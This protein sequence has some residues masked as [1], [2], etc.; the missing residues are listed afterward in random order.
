[1]RSFKFSSPVNDKIA[2]RLKKLDL[3]QSTVLNFGFDD[4]PEMDGEVLRCRDYIFQKLHIHIKIFMVDLVNDFLVDQ[5][6]EGL[7]IQHHSGFRVH[8]PFYGDLQ[9]IIVPMPVEVVA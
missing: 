5:F 9:N 1:M 4:V 3:M 6:F 2:F 8:F 7:E